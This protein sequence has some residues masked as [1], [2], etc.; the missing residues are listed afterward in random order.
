MS[1]KNN[2]WINISLEFFRVNVLCYEKVMVLS[3]PNSVHI[4]DIELS[5]ILKPLY[6]QGEKGFF[7]LYLQEQTICLLHVQTR[8]QDLVGIILA[9]ILSYQPIILPFTV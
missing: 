9:I 7:V 5:P 1:K 3:L 4:G 6:L 8:F 2:T